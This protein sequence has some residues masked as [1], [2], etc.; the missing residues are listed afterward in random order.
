MAELHWRSVILIVLSGLRADISVLDYNGTSGN[1]EIWFRSFMT[2]CFMNNLY[3][4]VK[5]FM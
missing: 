2:A 3:D 1:F 4:G 5:V